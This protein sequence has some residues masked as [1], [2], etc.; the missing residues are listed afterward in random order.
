MYKIVTKIIV[1]RLIPH[2]HKLV[3]P[4]QST[5]VSGRRS[6]DNAIVVQKLIHTISNKKGQV[7]YMTIK[8]DLEKVYDKIEWSFIRKVLINANLPHNLMALII[9]CVSLVSTSILFNG[10]NVDPIFPT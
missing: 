10:G 2:L 3:S 1:A 9:S 7:G 6:V 5:F 8:V 4:F